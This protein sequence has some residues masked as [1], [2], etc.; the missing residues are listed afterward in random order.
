MCTLSRGKVY[1]IQPMITLAAISLT[2]NRDLHDDVQQEGGGTASLVVEGQV[3][4]CVGMVQVCG[5]DSLSQKHHNDADQQQT[6]QDETEIDK[7][8]LEVLTRLLGHFNSRGSPDSRASKVLDFFH[9]A[10]KTKVGRQV[11]FK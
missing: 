7:E 5:G 10:R 6:Y 8:V 2:L 3:V 9:D 1:K 11:F 4:S